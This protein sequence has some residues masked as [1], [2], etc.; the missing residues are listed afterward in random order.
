MAE[1][2]QTISPRTPLNKS[3]KKDRVFLAP[4]PRLSPLRSSK[5]YYY[6]HYFGPGHFGWLFGLPQG[7]ALPLKCPDL[8]ACGLSAKAAAAPPKDIVSAIT[9][10]AINNETRFLI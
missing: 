2:Y 4:V 1:I 5:R 3:M 7:F 9:S 10:A 8:P 6:Y